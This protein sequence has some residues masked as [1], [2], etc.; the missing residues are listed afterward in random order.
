MPNVGLAL[1]QEIS[2]LAKK[3]AKTQVEG[4]RAATNRYRHEIAAL[5]RQLASLEKVVATNGRTYRRAPAEESENVPTPQIRF[6]AK[7]LPSLR[8]RLGLSS[9]DLALMLDVTSQSIYN[10]EHGVSRPRTAQLQKLASLRSAGKRQVQAFLAELKEKS[11]SR[12]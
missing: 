9:A 5:K 6:V 2:R 12:H 1:R 10:W 3:E 11:G 7:G 8:R 4:L